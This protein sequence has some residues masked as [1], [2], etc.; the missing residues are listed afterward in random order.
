MI[1]IKKKNY[2]YVIT[3]RVEMYRFKIVVFLQDILNL[4]NVFSSVQ[5]LRVDPVHTVSLRDFV[6]SQME[7]SQRQHGAQAF[8]MLMNTV[9]PEVLTQLKEFVQ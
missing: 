8:N 7:A 5:L 2:C 1:L 6:T 9:D 4:A 3:V